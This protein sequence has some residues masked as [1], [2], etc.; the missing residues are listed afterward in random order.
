MRYFIANWKAN[1]N[2]NEA[3]QWIDKFL[4][5]PLRS[6]RIKVIICP[7]YPLIFPLKEKIKNSKNIYL[8][9]QDLSI[10]ES[11]TFTGEV[12]AK[13][14]AGL[15]DYAIIGHSERREKFS[16]TDQTNFKKI[17]LAN[18]YNINPLLCIQNEKATIISDVKFIV[19]EPPWAISKGF[20]D[21]MQTK[22]EESPEAIIKVNQLLKLDN[23]KFFIY[24]GSVNPNNIKEYS[25]HPQIDGVLV[26]GA[27]LDPKVFYQIIDLSLS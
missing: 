18:K 13:T 1:K 4:T 14:L 8:G 23:N 6:D 15:A 26:G 21:S 25:K 24:G 2:L 9:S 11:G 27:S 3:V 5:L 16:E 20:R 17:A 10:Y 12:T 19:Y 7:P 22:I